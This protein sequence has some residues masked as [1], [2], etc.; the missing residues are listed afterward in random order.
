MSEI[1]RNFERVIKLVFLKSSFR[2]ASEEVNQNSSWFTSLVPPE[3]NNISHINQNLVLGSKFAYKQC[4]LK[5]YKTVFAYYSFTWNFRLQLGI[6]VDLEYLV[7][8]L[9]SISEFT[10]IVP[11]ASLVKQGSLQNKDKDKDMGERN[12]R[13]ANAGLFAGGAAEGADDENAAAVRD[14]HAENM[15]RMIRL[16]Q[17]ANYG[18]LASE[19]ASTLIPALTGRVS[20][21][22][23]RVENIIKARGVE[24]FED[25]ET[26]HHFLPAVLNKLTPDLAR[27]APTH[28]LRELLDYLKTVDRIRWDLNQCFAEGRK[29]D[30]PPRQAFSILMNRVR[31]ALPTLNEEGQQDDDGEEC[32]DVH[33]K[34][35]AWTSLKKG[36]PP[37]ILALATAMGIK[38]SPSNEQLE[39]LE[40]AWAEHAAEKE[41]GVFAVQSTKNEDL[42]AKQ[43]LSITNLISH[44]NKRLRDIETT[45]QQDYSHTYNVSTQPTNSNLRN[46]LNNFKGRGNGR[47]FRGS[48]SVGPRANN[49]QQRPYQNR[50]NFNMRNAAAQPSTSN[51]PRF[52]APAYPNR[53]DFCFY[54]RMFGQNARNHD[55]PCA[56]IFPSKQ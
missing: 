29:L 44:Q 52:P 10:G 51:G 12:N 24:N 16:M 6:V 8:K 27:D 55:L 25:P 41:S 30:K 42:V 15:A 3:R 53:A 19:T 34:S 49:I 37:N 21:W 46:N 7:N 1:L 32:N 54:H 26:V 18:L 20:T 35:V 38:Y 28:N 48:A 31:K 39:T 56:W 47:P 43:L 33:V 45:V 9:L 36:L 13:R 11:V 17:Q 50:Y 5:T 4:F 2:R 23:E 40:E 14:E 22:A